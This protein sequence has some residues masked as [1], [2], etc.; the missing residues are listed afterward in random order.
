MPLVLLLLQLAPGIIDAV[1]TSMARRE[2]I[3][4]QATLATRVR[5]ELERRALARQIAAGDPRVLR[6]RLLE[7]ARTHHSTRVPGMA[8]A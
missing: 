2:A 3:R 5:F 7:Y 6:R 1:S 8:G 4:Q